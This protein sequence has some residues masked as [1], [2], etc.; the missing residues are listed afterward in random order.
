[1]QDTNSDISSKQTMQQ[2]KPVP[3][4]K[5][6]KFFSFKSPMI[7]IEEYDSDTDNEEEYNLKG[8]M[9]QTEFDRTNISAQIEVDA[10]DPRVKT[11]SYASKMQASPG[12]VSNFSTNLGTMPAKS[13]GSKYH[14]ETDS[15]DVSDYEPD[16]DSD[17]ENE[18]NQ[19]SAFLLERCFTDKRQVER[20]RRKSAILMRAPRKKVTC[21][22]KECRRKNSDYT[23]SDE[24]EKDGQA[25]I[26]AIK[27]A[28]QSKRRM[29]AIISPF[30]N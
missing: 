6:K 28:I 25:S 4:P 11:I 15:D 7:P 23:S 10:F 12:V 18:R 21:G 2:L 3:V 16:V 24:D 29:T 30:N 17:W 1:M 13:N 5:G 20:M 9:N 26:S 8:S 19:V 22:H 14:Y 27:N